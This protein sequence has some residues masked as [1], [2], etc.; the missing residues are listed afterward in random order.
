[1]TTTQ[2][3][4]A[5]VAAIHA[6][7]ERKN[8]LID[9]IANT[10]AGIGEASGAYGE[11]F[12]RCRDAYTEEGRIDRELA[13]ARAERRATNVATLEARLEQHRIA[14]EELEQRAEQARHEKDRLTA[15]LDRLEREELPACQQATSLEEVKA[16]QDEIAALQQEV[17]NL[18]EAIA[19]R[20]RLIQEI[21]D[22]LPAMAVRTAERC[23]LLA[24]VATNQATQAQ[25]DEL[26]ARI[27]AEQREHERVRG[28]VQAAIDQAEQ[29]IAG[30]ERM[31]MDVAARKE[32]LEALS[33]M[34]MEQFVRSKI[35]ALAADYVATAALLADLFIQLNGAEMLLYR[36]IGTAPNLLGSQE[37]TIPAFNLDACRDAPRRGRADTVFLFRG[38]IEGARA[39]AWHK[40]VTSEVARLRNAGITLI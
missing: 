16:H 9:E 21:R 26:D 12:Q 30:L 13:K 37:L 8:A 15:A 19:G 5:T 14:T 32:A 20:H 23:D 2:S 4:P 34:V 3:K 29:T 1:M 25:V 7:I 36:V 10:R 22:E 28:Q 6:R 31:R 38:E 11:L 27:E 39:T 35:D 40:A 33:P 17:A 24:Q 18:D